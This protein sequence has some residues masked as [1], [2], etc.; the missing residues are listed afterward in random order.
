MTDNIQSIT[1]RDES[2]DERRNLENF[3]G[4]AE[5]YFFGN[6]FANNQTI[7]VAQNL[8]IISDEDKEKKVTGFFIDHENKKESENSFN[9]Q[10][11]P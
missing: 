4:S 7:P 9:L 11:W 6:F 8:D 5:L 1:A 2:M 3:H 10:R